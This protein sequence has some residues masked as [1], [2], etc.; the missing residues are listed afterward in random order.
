MSDQD[1]TEQLIDVHPSDEN[2]ENP[3]DV[4]GVQTNPYGISKCE[5][6][7]LVGILGAIGLGVFT[8]LAAI[9]CPILL[10]V[11]WGMICGA[12]LSYGLIVWFKI[13]YRRYKNYREWEDAH[14]T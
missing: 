11:V 13:I 9:Y 4:E 3:V 6:I 7:G 2:S 8:I 5:K 1:T 12:I 14:A 10:G